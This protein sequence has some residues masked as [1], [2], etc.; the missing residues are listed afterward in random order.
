MLTHETMLAA[1]ARSYPHRLALRDGVGREVAFG[2]LHDQVSAVAS[3]LL[4][5]GARPGECVAWLSRNRIDYLVAFYAAARAG[6]LFSPINYWL[7]EPEIRPLL[8]LLR[9][10]MVICE[11]EFR[12]IMDV[13]TAGSEVRTRVILDADAADGW[14]TWQ[15]LIKAG[16]DDAR[17]LPSGDENAPHEIIFTSG[18]T[19]EQKA[20]LRSQR[21]RLMD[22]FM[23]ALGFGLS[24][25]DH[26]LWFLPQFHVGGAGTTNMLL[27]QGGCVTVMREF[28]ERLAARQI[29]NGVTCI[30]GVPTTFNLLCDSG[31]L[32]GVDTSGVRACF[33]GG[34]LADRSIFDKISLHFPSAEMV[35]CYGSTESGPHS[36]TIRGRAL[37]ER[38]DSVGLPGAGCE[39][40]VVR[41]DGT[42][43]DPEEVG[44]LWLRSEAVMAGYFRRDDL[45]ANALTPDRWLRTGDLVKR[46][47]DGY[48][49]VMDRLVDKIIT[50]GENVYSK[51]VEDV[52]LA[53]N[54]VA[55]VAV[56]GI[57]DP[58]REERIVAYIRTEPGAQLG[59]EELAAFARARLAGYKVP[60][61]FHFADDLPRTP[62][63]KVSKVLL[64]VRYHTETAGT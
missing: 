1:G 18:T 61:E 21:S 50:G 43:A 39:A 28:D 64:K 32:K 3:A 34:S 14:V 31:E 58:A 19:G 59:A 49:Y 8:K 30:S 22:S 36:V 26:L 54:L 12:D 27:S 17:S 42:D 47:K 23:G 10:T 52:L 41:V 24:R 57:R 15:D 6:L 25:N 45:T 55:E 33:V 46:D 40:R 4:E 13:T 2:E 53:H 63:G 29:G 62:I 11:A 35:Q 38:P 5:H 60:T 48:L 16:M 37:A 7:R 9:P 44:E 56:I 51:E 20:V